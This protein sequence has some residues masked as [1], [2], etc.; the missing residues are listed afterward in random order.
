[1][2]RCGISRQKLGGELFFDRGDRTKWGNFQSSDPVHH[3]Y[4]ESAEHKIEM[5]ED[6]WSWDRG[7]GYVAEPGKYARRRPSAALASELNKKNLSSG[8]A[9]PE[10][11]ISSAGRE[12]EIRSS[13]R[14]IYGFNF[15]GYKVIDRSC[16][17][18]I[19]EWI[20][21]VSVW[22]SSESFRTLEQSVLGNCR[23][24][25]CWVGQSPGCQHVRKPHDKNLQ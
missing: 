18:R 24:G 4:C 23:C 19:P 15:R 25:I 9:Y 8:V 13:Q 6:R 7:D 22:P 10:P 5:F 14:K 2:S 17:C 20:D 16:F 3:L 12:F 1:M 11:R 21:Q